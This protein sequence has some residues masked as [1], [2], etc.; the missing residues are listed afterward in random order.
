MEV[1]TPRHHRIGRIG[2]PNLHTVT[3]ECGCGWAV[4]MDRLDNALDAFH[5]HA[6]TVTAAAGICQPS[7]SFAQSSL[8]SYVYLPLPTVVLTW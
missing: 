5:S 4:T 3:V 6:A 8:T 1:P 2:P 7:G